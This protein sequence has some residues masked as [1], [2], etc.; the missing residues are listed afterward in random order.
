M[1]TF[2]VFCTD[3]YG[4]CSTWIS[5]VEARDCAHAKEVAS[6]QC[7]RDWSVEPDAIHILGVA[8]GDVRILDWND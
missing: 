5:A 4:E 7:A 6:A 3:T 8:E 2:T 1:A